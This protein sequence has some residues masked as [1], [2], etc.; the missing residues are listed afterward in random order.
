MASMFLR[1][2]E[3]EAGEI[4]V[5]TRAPGS[6]CDGGVYGPQMKQE[7]NCGHPVCHCHC[8]GGPGA[9]PKAG[10]PR[11]CQSWTLMLGSSENLK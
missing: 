9:G 5:Q 6:W 3:S 2:H 11:K 4:G 8:V 1:T 10:G 7:D